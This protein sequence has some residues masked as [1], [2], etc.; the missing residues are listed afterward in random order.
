MTIIQAREAALAGKLA[1]YFE[2]MARI[3]GD[4]IVGHG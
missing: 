1:E 4:E 2:S 3:S